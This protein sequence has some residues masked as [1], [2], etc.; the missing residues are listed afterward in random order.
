MKQKQLIRKVMLHFILIHLTVAILHL[1]SNQI[2]H[3][4]FKY[5]KDWHFALQVFILLGANLIFYALI[6]W[7]YASVFKDRKR[8][9]LLIEWPII[10]L[11]L[12]SLAAFA[13]I[14]FFSMHLY[15]KDIM[16]IYAVLNPWYGTY[17]IKMSEEYIYSL[18][19]I[20]S[21]VMPVFGFYLGIRTQLLVKKEE[22]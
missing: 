5:F 12:L 14:Y 18:W 20:L 9:S 13:I 6:G 17:L 16:L 21:S 1:L 8:L 15:N 11:M 2:S 19:W 7:I 3:P 10:F 22:R 4:F